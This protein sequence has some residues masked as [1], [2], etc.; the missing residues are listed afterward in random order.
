MQ[1][2][3]IRREDDRMTKGPTYGEE[4]PPLPVFI[5]KG[6]EIKQTLRQVE[7]NEPLELVALDL[8]HPEN[9]V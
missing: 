5:D 9:T 7:P 3:K 1:E 8:S 4:P 6:E 2:H